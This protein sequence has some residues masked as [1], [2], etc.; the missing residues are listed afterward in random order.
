MADQPGPGGPRP[1]GSG[2][3]GS[4]PGAAA[5]GGARPDDAFGADL[6]GQLPDGNLVFSP[7]SIAGMLRMA[8]LGARGQ[9]AAQLAAALREPAPPAAGGQAAGA[10]AAA[11]AGLAAL[12]TAVTELARGGITLGAPTTLWLQE[13]FPVVP[14]YTAALAGLAGA[15][16]RA[17]DFTRDAEQ[18]RQAINALIAEQTAGRISGLLGPGAVASGSRLVLASALYLRAAW[19]QPFPAAATGDGPFYPDYPAGTGPGPAASARTV[20]LMRLRGRLGYLRGDGYQAVLLRYAGQRLAMAVLLPDGP[21]APLERALARGGSGPLVA[22]AAPRPVILTLPRFRVT[23]RLPLEQPLTGL[24]I[25]DAF[26]PAA[27]FTGLSPVPQL[28]LNRVVHQ[29][30]IDVNEQGTEAAAAT[31]AGFARPTAVFRAD[32]PVEVTVDHPF[33]FAITDTGTGLPLFL[34]RVTDP[35]A[36]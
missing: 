19:A 9:T 23:A 26:R 31:A 12:S 5:P 21:L 34:G 22:G 20:A 17:A 24:G 11:R 7:A 25:T 33:L 32:P 13:G 18:A 4:G 8:L 35:A 30:F 28:H 29:A 3:G 27:D 1:G 2:P 16:V 36:G 15:A 6:Y 10:G 14:E